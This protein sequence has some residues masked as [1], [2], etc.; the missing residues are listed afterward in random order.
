MKFG[1]ILETK[2]AEKAWNALRFATTSRKNG[3]EV[4]VFLMGEAVECENLTHE[5]FDVAGQLKAFMAAGGTILACGTCLK[6]RQMN[7]TEACPLSTMI[8]CIKM[9]EWADK[10]ITF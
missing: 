7:G 10:V 8:D 3:H 2:E 1:I 5:K 6:S 9:V 4:K